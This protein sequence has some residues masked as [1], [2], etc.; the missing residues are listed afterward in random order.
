[1][2]MGLRLD[3]KRT[4]RSDGIESQKTE[5]DLRLRRR[6]VVLFYRGLRKGKF[7]HAFQAPICDILLLSSQ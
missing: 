4:M 3:W 1:M 2:Q 5:G 6:R 7:R